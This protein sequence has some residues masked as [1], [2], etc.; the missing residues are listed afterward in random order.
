M[1]SINVRFTYLGRQQACSRRTWSGQQVRGASEEGRNDARQSCVGRV[2]AVAETVDQTEQHCRH[3][4]LAPCHGGVHVVVV[5]AQAVVGG[6]T[7]VGGVRTQ[8][9]EDETQTP[10]TSKVRAVNH[11]FCTTGQ[12]HHQR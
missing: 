2:D 3:G 8:S 11:A 7:G 9:S 6:L 1:R 4:V 10:A 5:Q 12:P